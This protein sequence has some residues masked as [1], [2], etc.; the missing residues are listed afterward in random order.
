MTSMLS[1]GRGRRAARTAVAAGAVTLGLV[2]LSACEKP[3]PRA[4]MVAGSTS[5]ST[6]AACYDHGKKLSEK[7]IADCTKQKPTRSLTVGEGDM[8]RLGVDPEIAETGWVLF[9][10]G[11][12]AIEPITKTYRSFPSDAFFSRQDPMGGQEQASS[13]NVSIVQVDGDNY[14]G[15]WNIELKNN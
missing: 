5:V 10:N 15:V 1:G 14:K 9:L 2:A 12:Q 11:Q 8:L 7:R 13:V 6:E 3:T 4:T